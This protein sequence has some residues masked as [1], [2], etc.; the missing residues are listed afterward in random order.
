VALKFEEYESHLHSI[1]NKLCL[2]IL[3]SAPKPGA[4]LGKGAQMQA[5]QSYDGNNA[6]PASTINAMLHNPVNAFPYM[7]QE[8]ISINLL[9][10][11]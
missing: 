5:Q 6:K 2:R 4:I 11:I 3:N 10:S 8:T 1:C 7:L 9:S